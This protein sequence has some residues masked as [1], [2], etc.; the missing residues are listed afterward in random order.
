MDL[1]YTRDFPVEHIYLSIT[2]L[3]PIVFKL[4]TLP[5]NTMTQ[6]CPRTICNISTPSVLGD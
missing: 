3:R 5:S 2:T 4:K 1:Y 6:L